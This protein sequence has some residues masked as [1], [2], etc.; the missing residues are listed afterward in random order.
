MQLQSL[1]ACNEFLSHRKE[2]PILNMHWNC[3]VKDTLSYNL[4]WTLL[5][6]ILYSPPYLI[7]PL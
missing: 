6:P 2:K 5:L 4:I 7:E 1:V 3:H